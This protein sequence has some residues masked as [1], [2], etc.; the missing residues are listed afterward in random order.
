MYKASQELVDILEKNGFRNKSHLYVPDY[1]EKYKF[2]EP[3]NPGA[4]KREYGMGYGKRHLGFYFD[5]INMVVTYRSTHISETYIE[6]DKCQLRSIIAYFKCSHARQRTIKYATN[7]RIETAGSIMKEQ[8]KLNYSD[9]P[10]DEA[11]E[12]LYNDVIL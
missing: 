1:G 2:V 12:K 8:R 10:F 7:F 5:Y 9:A 3:Y 4:Y 6:F 11:F